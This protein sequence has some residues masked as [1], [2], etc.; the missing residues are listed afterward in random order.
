MTPKSIE[1][2]PKARLDRSYFCFSIVLIA[3]TSSLSRQ[4]GLG[5]GY[6]SP[7]RRDVHATAK[8]LPLA[9]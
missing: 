3:G 2:G 4:T 5:R 9:T 1:A 7:R 8:F 6:E